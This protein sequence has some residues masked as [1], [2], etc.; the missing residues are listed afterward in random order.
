LLCDQRLPGMCG[1]ELIQTATRRGLIQ[2]AIL[3]SG[4]EAAPL[5]TLESEAR[6]MGLPLLGCLSKP[7]NT[8]ELISLISAPA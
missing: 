3:L 5:A 1:L 2:R 7:L 8:L 4:L 6:A